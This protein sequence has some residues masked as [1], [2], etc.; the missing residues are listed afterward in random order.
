MESNDQS[1]RNS[2]NRLD[3]NELFWVFWSGKFKIII[4]TAIFAVC[5]IFYSLSLQN[6]YKATAILAPSTGGISDSLNQAGGIAS[7][8]GI[9]LGGSSSGTDT[10]HA[11][12]IMQSWSYIDNFVQ[13]NELIPILFAAE[14][15]DQQLGKIKYNQD[16]YDITTKTWKTEAQLPSSWEIFQSFSGIL[17][18]ENDKA[19]L[20]KISIEYIS[21]DI[22][23][24]L[25]DLYVL[26][27]NK[28]MQ[29]RKVQMVTKNIEYLEAQLAGNPISE[30]KEVFFNIISEQIKLKM[31]AAATPEYV[32]V[33]VSPSMVP[34][35]RSQPNRTLICI[36]G[37]FLGGV[38]SVFLVIALHYGRQKN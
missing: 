10:E 35:K 23:K 8:A 22:A 27:I 14:G 5:S 37:T 21:P 28:Y 32:F 6:Q 18:V 30:M 36:L 9:S 19:G 17:S 33:T 24:M 29:E 16:L 15:W 13:T 34:E 38:F 7:F 2:E 31:M 20:T 3:L 1:S 12:E 11:R 4:I 26:S 25:V